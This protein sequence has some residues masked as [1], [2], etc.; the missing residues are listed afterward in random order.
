MT[1][2]P[3]SIL[4]VEDNPAD[5]GLLREALRDVETTQFALHHVE[6]LD[7]ALQYLETNP[8]DIVLLDLS[9]PDA[10]GMDSVRRTHTAV[11]HM[12]IV[13]LTGN[14]DEEI[15][16]QAVQM[17]A[18]DYLI[19]GQVDG[20]LLTRAIRYAIER[21]QTLQTLA[22]SERKLRLL[23]ANMKD[24]VFAYDMNSQVQYVNPAFEKLTGY[25]TAELYQRNFINFIHPEDE[26]VL[27]QLWQ[28]ALKGQGFEDV[29]HRI[30]TRDEQTKWCATSCSP[31]FDEAG[32]QV[33]IQGRSVDITER[34]RAEL[35]LVESEQCFRSTLS[36]MQEGLLI[37]DPEG[38]I[39]LCNDSASRILGLTR[40]Q[41]IGHKIT[42]LGLDVISEDGSPLPVEQYPLVLSLSLGQPQHCVVVGIRK[43]ASALT[44][45]SISS[46]PLV[47]PREVKP[48]SAIATFTDITEQRSQT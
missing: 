14:N 32:Q 16:L 24:T 45:L 20:N 43:A 29:E 48:Y 10:H 15:A 12:P 1:N 18:Q 47:R 27:R 44:W 21:K 40:N 25:T 41:I 42:E 28:D 35:D 37:T 6:R 7:T 8:A 23:A 33:G 34:K 36:A 5:A 2:Q 13:V 3:I 9:L 4:L 38:R 30:I 19:K 17:G 26:P 31:A 22:E 11:P 39:T 46:T